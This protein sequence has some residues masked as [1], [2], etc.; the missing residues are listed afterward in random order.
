VQ[1]F[2]ES[3]KGK[4]WDLYDYVVGNSV[5][6]DLVKDVGTHMNKIP[7]KMIKPVEEGVVGSRK[8]FDPLPNQFGNPQVNAGGFNFNI[9]SV[10][11]N[12]NESTSPTDMKRYVE[13]VATQ[14]AY[15]VFRQ[16]TQFGGL[17]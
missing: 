9:A 14:V 17:L 15:N 11:T 12:N 2:T 13:N 8:A 1:N 16:N 4:F 7:S 5:I 3:A 10:N 6:P